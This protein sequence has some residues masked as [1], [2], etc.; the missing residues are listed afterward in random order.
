MPVEMNAIYLGRLRC[1]ATH[2]PSKATVTTDAPSDNMGRGEAFSPTDMVGV[3]LGTCMLTTM[4]IAAQRASIDMTGA[5]CR[6]VKDMIADPARRIGS[7][8]VEIKMPAALSE[9]NRRKLE[10]AAMGC[11][12]HKSLHP[13]VKLPV[14]FIYK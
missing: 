11:P 9:D 2:G 1:N 7:L 12:V 8:H 10:A 14:T 6:I 3:A 4:G 13:D 5:T